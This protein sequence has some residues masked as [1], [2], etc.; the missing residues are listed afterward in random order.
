MNKYQEALDTIK[1]VY[2]YEAL[3]KYPTKT[4]AITC[5]KECATIQ[6]LVDRATPKKVADMQVYS[7]F[8]IGGFYDTKYGKCPH[9]GKAVSKD[10]NPHFCQFEGCGQA[11]DWEVK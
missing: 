7:A 3:V 11:L 1:G 8:G 10:I 5:K 6:E 9:C 2:E 4:L